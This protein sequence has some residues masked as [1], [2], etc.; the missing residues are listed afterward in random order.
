MVATANHSERSHDK[1]KVLYYLHL[2]LVSTPATPSFI[3]QTLSTSR[4]LCTLNNYYYTLLNAIDWHLHSQLS[5]T[6]VCLI[7]LMTSV[8]TTTSTF[9]FVVQRDCDDRS[10][11]STSIVVLWLLA[12]SYNVMQPY[13]QITRL[14]VLIRTVRTSY[15]HQ[16]IWEKCIY[17]L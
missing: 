11:T 4:C 9:T 15:K 6:Q 3:P 13:K 2:W 16:H 5:V 14:L 1:S 7:D 12:F 17:V 8:E 10:N